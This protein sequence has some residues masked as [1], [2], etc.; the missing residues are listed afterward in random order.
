[1]ISALCSV[2][3]TPFEAVE[4]FLE[5][6][7]MLVVMSV[8]PGF[9]GQEFSDDALSII[10][11]ARIFLDSHGLSADIEVDG[12]ITADNAKR[13]RAAGVPR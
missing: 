9:G 5:I 6:C 4:P 8:E 7:S 11:Q 3:G 2:R 1:M 12:G 10:E 13:A